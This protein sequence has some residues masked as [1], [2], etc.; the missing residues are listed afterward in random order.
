MGNKGCG[1]RAEGAHVA[2][3]EFL[4]PPRASSAASTRAAG[5]RAPGLTRFLGDRV[6]SDTAYTQAVLPGRVRALVQPDL[7]EREMCQT[8]HRAP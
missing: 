8:L 1:E 7:R 5:S 6:D 3:P 4:S 2:V